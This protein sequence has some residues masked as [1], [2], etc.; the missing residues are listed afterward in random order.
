[1]LLRRMPFLMMFIL[2]LGLA[3]NAQSAFF[4]L[5]KGEVQI[6]KYT[7]AFNMGNNDLRFKT[8]T[9]NTTESINGKEYLVV[10]SSYGSK[11]PYNLVSTQYMR[12][13]DNGSIMGV[14]KN[15]SEQYFL[16][17]PLIVGKSWT[18]I[19]NGVTVT[20]KIVD[21][22]GSIQASG[23]TYSNCLV[24]EMNSTD[25][26]TKSYFQEDRGLVAMAMIV[27]QEEK[28]FIYRIE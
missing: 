25:N 16:E 27:D 7:D 11:E 4:P 12:I 22:N 13:L 18:Q 19:A 9:L 26:R 8:E 28:L 6:Y 15:E 3:S 24:L 1:M 2:S 23:K 17:Y 10:Q 14:E 21:L 5:K 20:M